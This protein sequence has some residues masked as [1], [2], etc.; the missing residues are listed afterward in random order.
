MTDLAEGMRPPDGEVIRGTVVFDKATFF[1]QKQNRA[2]MIGGPV[3]PKQHRVLRKDVIW[4]PK[5]GTGLGRNER[6][7]AFGDVP[8]FSVLN[9]IGN[10]GDSK[11]EFFKKYWIAG[12]ST[13]TM[14]SNALKTDSSIYSAVDKMGLTWMRNNGPRAIHAGDEVM[15]DIPA[16]TAD[17]ERLEK[18]LGA[19]EGGTPENRFTA[20]PTVWS[21]GKAMAEIVSDWSAFLRG[22]RGAGATALPSTTTAARSLREQTVVG[23]CIA[24][25]YL[26]VAQAPPDPATL[27]AQL[28]AAAS[29]N[30]ASPRAV[31]AMRLINEVM[32]QQHDDAIAALLFPSDGEYIVPGARIDSGATLPTRTLHSI[33]KVGAT[34]LM[35]AVEAGIDEAGRSRVIGRC[36]HN[37]K[38]GDPLSILLY[39]S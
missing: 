34:N 14:E 20:F 4:S 22:E 15:I 12:L 24:F 1:R 30:D 29:G 25:G 11:F 7:A 38:V 33:Q 10:A 28:R 16:S 39:G 2:P 26:D 36:Q 3:G 9:G 31:N 17:A 6:A 21:V 35:T 18:S 37:S 32:N 13:G 19:P 27:I 23:I 8:V 5:P